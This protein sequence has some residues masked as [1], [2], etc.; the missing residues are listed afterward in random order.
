MMAECYKEHR[1]SKI[2]IGFLEPIR[3][4]SPWFGASAQYSSYRHLESEMADIH[5][6]F[7]S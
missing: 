2:T 5:T 1:I 6:P 4:L 3:G 7:P